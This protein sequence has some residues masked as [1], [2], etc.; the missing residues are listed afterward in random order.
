[1]EGGG[2]REWGEAPG[3]REVIGVLMGESMKRRG[4]RRKG[5]EH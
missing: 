1:M 3:S 2:T 4:K 5:L